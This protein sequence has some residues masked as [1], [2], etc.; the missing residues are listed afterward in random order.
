M[1]PIC[2]TRT[3]FAFPHNRTKQSM[4][5]Y[6]RCMFLGDYP[7]W[8]RG[9]ESAESEITVISIRAMGVYGLVESFILAGLNVI[10]I[11]KLC[12]YTAFRKQLNSK[13]ITFTDNLVFY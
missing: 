9:C 6:V 2:R 8:E 13:L 5:P 1:L 3:D 10:F 11:L 12:F 7:L 4:E